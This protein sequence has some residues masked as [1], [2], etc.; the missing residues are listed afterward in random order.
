MDQ[1]R[2]A[3]PKALP[4]IPPPQ[5]ASGDSKHI[6]LPFTQTLKSKSSPTNLLPLTN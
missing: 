5:T 6:V 4:Q 3:H 1:F 2:S